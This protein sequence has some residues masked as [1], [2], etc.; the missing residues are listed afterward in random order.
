MFALSGGAAH[1][2][3]SGRRGGANQS[4]YKDCL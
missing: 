2:E 3:A 1:L 4:A